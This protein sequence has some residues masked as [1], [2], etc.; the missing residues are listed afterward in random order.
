MDVRLSIIVPTID[1]PLG[2]GKPAPTL[3]NCLS[4][5]LGLKPHEILVGCDGEI[6]AVKDLCYE[7]GVKCHNF[8]LTRSYGNHQRHELQKVATGTHVLFMDHDD[9]YVDGAGDL[10]R[11]SVAVWPDRPLFFTS[12]DNGKETEW[13]GSVDVERFVLFDAGSPID[14][15]WLNGPRFLYRPH[16]FSIVVPVVEG[17]PLWSSGTE[18]WSDV[19][20]VTKVLEWFT[21][22]GKSP[23]Y[24]HEP[25]AEKRPWG[26]DW[27]EDHHNTS[28]MFKN[29]SLG[30]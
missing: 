14:D 28:E 6:P 21:R 2:S 20:Y 12:L 5:C 15:W 16:A 26:R 19:I 9:G 23:V 25:I 13:T 7:M 18:R 3:A 1:V 11:E 27:I 30:N 10:I 22:N 24:I 17:A 4:T 29:K 8:P